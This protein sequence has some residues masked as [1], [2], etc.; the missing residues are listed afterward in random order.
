[1]IKYGN[2]NTNPLLNTSHLSERKS[3]KLTVPWRCV[4]PRS[5][6]PF[7]SVSGV[8]ST[9]RG[10][11]RTEAQSTARGAP[12]DH[13]PLVGGARWRSMGELRLG[14]SVTWSFCVWTYRQST[15]FLSPYSLMYLGHGLLRWYNFFGLGRKYGWTYESSQ[16]RIFQVGEYF[17]ANK[18]LLHGKKIPLTHSAPDNFFSNF[19]VKIGYVTHICPYKWL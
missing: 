11:C 15:L 2:V 17:R 14:R 12:G 16:Y 8:L 10:P 9:R 7:F 19:F 1:M 4:H 3:C 18:M 13:N 5:I 6:L